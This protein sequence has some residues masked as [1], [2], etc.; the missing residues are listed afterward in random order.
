MLLN[1]FIKFSRRTTQL[2][3][4]PLFTSTHV[5]KRNNIN[6][7][8]KELLKI[9]KLNHVAIATPDLA[10]S[11][12]MYKEVLGADVSEPMEL[13]DHGVT[14]VF[15]NLGNTKL[16]LLQPLGPNSPVTGFLQKKPE[17][18]MHH[19]CLEVKDIN[20]A[21]QEISKK[22]IRVLDKPKIGAHG[23]PVVFLH[24]KDC[25]GVLIE[26]EQL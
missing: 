26:V 22:G 21:V 9:G 15:V 7:S 17:G 1:T 10:K 3:S 18:G 8:N 5:Q 11:S 6:I 2:L 23:K 4:P 13:P 14:T 20:V 24:P 16:E 25:G 19:I 12:K